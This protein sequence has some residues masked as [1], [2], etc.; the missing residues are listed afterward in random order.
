MLDQQIDM[1]VVM[2]HRELMD[3][4][5]SLAT[6]AFGLVAALAWNTL[7]QNL[8]TD[9][10]AKYFPKSSVLWSLLYAVL[11]TGLA[12]WVTV[13]LSRLAARIVRREETREPSQAEVLEEAIVKALRRVRMEQEAAK[14]GHADA[15]ALETDAP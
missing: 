4:M 5:V 6:S 9:Y 2:I 13:A 14:L 10:I 15:D 12:V 1:E 8:I 7:I 11:V 3:K